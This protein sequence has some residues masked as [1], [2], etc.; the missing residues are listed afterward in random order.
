MTQLLLALIG[1]LPLSYPIVQGGGSGVVAEQ[2]APAVESRDSRPATQP[3]PAATAPDAA[4]AGEVPADQAAAGAQAEAQ[5]QAR[6]EELAPVAGSRSGT[7]PAPTA[8][9][10]T[11]AP[12]P[13]PT[14][15]TTTPSTTT[16]PPARATTPS[17]G[18]LSWAPPA[19]WQNYPVTRITSTNSVTTVSGK[20]G[21]V[22]VQ[23]PA[24]RPAAPIIIANCRNAVVMGGQINVLPT[25]RIGN[26]DQ[27]AVYVHK[28]TG[29]VHIEGVL[30]NGNVAG[31]QADGIAVNAPEA[32]VQI[33]NVRMD[34]LRGTYSVNH[35]DVF[36]PWGGVREYRIDRLTGTTNY[37]GIQVRQDLGAIGKGTI[38][39]AN[40]GSSEVNPIER[41]GQFI[42]IDCNTYPL[43]LENVYLDPRSGRDMGY[44]VWPQTDDRSCPAK[45]S[46]GVVSW[47][48]IGN[49]SGTLS[50]GKPA[51]GD[52]VPA[53]SVGIGYVSPGYR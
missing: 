38:R 35:A 48:S 22:L 12:A 10:T 45:I 24:D 37:Q 49:L 11:P 36:Q 41:G 39:N 5:A 17:T 27:R 18:A 26:D 8:T 47:P 2:A 6:A 44:S 21:D 34:A 46:N 20:G 52:F 51:S 32:T 15:A 9:T 28:C 42:R 43:A 19:G 14:T 53:G 13:K 4:P 25:A 40:V 7:G 23:L 30:I 3:P 33:Q 50:Q 1:I 16:A 29:T 31:S